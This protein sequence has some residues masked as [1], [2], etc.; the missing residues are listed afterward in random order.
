MVR[1][2]AREK[3]VASPQLTWF[4]TPHLRTGAFAHAAS[5]ALT[6]N[7]LVRE[8]TIASQKEKRT[9]RLTSR[10]RH[11][12]AARTRTLTWIPLTASVMD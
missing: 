10:T 5:A 1:A 12:R 7:P 6:T 8:A 4:L 3:Y 11:D 2:H 9:V